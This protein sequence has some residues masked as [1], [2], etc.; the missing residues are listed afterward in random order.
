MVIVRCAGGYSL[1]LLFALGLLAFGF[2]RPPW[3]ARRRPLPRPNRIAQARV[4]IS[5]WPDEPASPTEIDPARFT[6]A[7]RTICGWMP[8]QRGARY[9]GWILQYAHEFEVDP[10][11]LAAL[12]YREGRCRSDAEDGDRGSGIGLTL[13]HRPMYAE[14]LRHGVLRFRVREDGAWV[15][16]ERPLE[17]LPLRRAAP[18]PARAQP[19]LRRGAPPPLARPARERGRR[20]RARAASALRLALGVG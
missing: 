14:N 18:E 16:R 2:D 11:L 19:L 7:L 4:H 8:P 3:Y 10:F 12:V 1:V 9:T 6:E 15:E 13:I 5:D 17:S 20:V